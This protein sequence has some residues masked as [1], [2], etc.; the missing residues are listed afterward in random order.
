M[1]CAWLQAWTHVYE[2]CPQKL[3][4]YYPWPCEDNSSQGQENLRV[5]EIFLCEE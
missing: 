3:E 4:Y 5:F 1:I 2:E